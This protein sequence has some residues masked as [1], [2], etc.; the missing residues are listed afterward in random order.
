[1][2][3]AHEAVHDLNEYYRDLKIARTMLAKEIEER[4]ALLNH[5]KIKLKYYE[6]KYRV[7]G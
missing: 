5:I 7:K 4:Q 1:M 2:I 3:D 6:K